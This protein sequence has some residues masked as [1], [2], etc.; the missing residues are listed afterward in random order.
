MSSS[1]KPVEDI[2][3]LFGCN[4]SVMSRYGN[5]E[6]KLAGFLYKQNLLVLHVRVT[7]KLVLIPL[8]EVHELITDPPRE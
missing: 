1:V 7:D 5:Y 4:V 2:Q 6:G 3:D 8:S